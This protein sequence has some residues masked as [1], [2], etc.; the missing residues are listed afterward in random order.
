MPTPTALDTAMANSTSVFKTRFQSE[1]SLASS[2]FIGRY[3]PVRS[4]RHQ[5]S[6]TTWQN[7]SVVEGWLQTEDKKRD[8]ERPQGEDLGGGE[9]HERHHSQ[10]V[11]IKHLSTSVDRTP[12]N[13]AGCA[14]ARAR[15]YG[16][17]IG[18]A[19]W[20]TCAPL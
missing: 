5:E 14:W 12:V 2:P 19:A 4:A 3:Y 17:Y 13:I 6:M 11:G 8:L 20:H 15:R 7:D 18:A 16:E 10:R 9:D 1:S